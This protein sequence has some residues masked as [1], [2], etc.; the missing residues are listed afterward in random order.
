LCL[1]PAVL[2]DIIVTLYQWTCFPVYG[3]PRVVRGDYIVLDRHYLAYLNVI[4]KLNCLYC[5]YFNGLMAYVTEVAGRTEQYWC[6][7]KH[8]TQ[9]KVFPSRYIRV[10]DEGDAQDYSKKQTSLRGEFAD[11]VEKHSQE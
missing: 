10:A 4:E 3:I 11:L 5:G 8:A 9:L 7:I 6:P 1:I 2:L